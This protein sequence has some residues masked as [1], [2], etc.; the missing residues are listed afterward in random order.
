MAKRKKIEKAT[1]RLSLD[2][3]KELTNEVNSKKQTSKKSSSNNQEPNSKQRVKLTTMI[4]PQ[5]RDQLK[6][7]A[8]QKGVKFSDL[9]EEVIK[10]YLDQK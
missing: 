10:E 6:I 2:Q 8:I 5:L 4:N 9:L 3:A 7:L 1:E